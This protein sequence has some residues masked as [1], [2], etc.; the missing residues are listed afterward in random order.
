MALE[1]FERKFNVRLHS[2]GDGESYGADHY[3]ERFEVEG[4]IDSDMLDFEVRGW[5]EDKEGQV[6][7]LLEV[8]IEGDELN[9]DIL[10]DFRRGRWKDLNIKV[11]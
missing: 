9:L 7:V 5:F 3:A 8:F 4:L 10:G 1:T 11:T 2:L 6:D